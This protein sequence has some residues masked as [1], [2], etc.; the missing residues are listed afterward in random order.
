MAK[1]P[2]I[3]LKLNK[4]CSSLTVLKPRSSSGRCSGL[5]AHTLRKLEYT[6]ATASGISVHT[7]ACRTE[8]VTEPPI[9][10]TATVMAVDHTP[11]PE[12]ERGRKRRGRE[13]IKTPTRTDAGRRQKRGKKECDR[14]RGHNQYTTN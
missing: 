11:W 7:I 14:T 13:N 3:R 6:I 2:L 10:G 8:K 1:S 5:L 9:G 4:I 12:L